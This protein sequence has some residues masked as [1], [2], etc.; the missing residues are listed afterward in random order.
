MHEY[1]LMV[2][3]P[4]VRPRVV[5]RLRGTMPNRALM[6]RHP[7]PHFPWQARAVGQRFPGAVMVYHGEKLDGFFDILKSAGSAV[8][9]AVKGVFRD[10]T[11]TLPG[12]VDVP[13]KDLPNVIRGASVRFGKTPGPVEQFVEQVPGGVGTIATVAA[14]GLGALLLMG[15]RKR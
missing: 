5:M 6:V 2:A 13:A 10:S 8:V 11:V 7:T 9:G 14:V 3:R 4:P 12:G 1:K 15:S